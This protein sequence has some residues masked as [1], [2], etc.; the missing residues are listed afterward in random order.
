MM[1]QDDPL[2]TAL[3]VIRGYHDV[4]PLSNLEKSV[5][6]PLVVGRLA[7]TISVAA[8]RRTIDPDHP[9]WF[10]SERQAWEL[11]PLLRRMEP[12]ALSVF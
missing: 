11:L 4:R 7:V 3:T 10:D 6:L 8:R 9:N 2:G 1:D 12:H 5:L